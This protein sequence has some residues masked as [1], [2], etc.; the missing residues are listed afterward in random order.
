MTGYGS[1]TTVF[2]TRTCGGDRRE[3]VGGV[4]QGRDDSSENTTADPHL[5]WEVKHTQ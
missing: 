3:G 5:Q 4:P 1:L 2:I